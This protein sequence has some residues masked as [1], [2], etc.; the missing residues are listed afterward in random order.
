MHEWSQNIALDW[1]KLPKGEYFF[2]VAPLAR[3]K[4]LK[5]LGLVP[6][7]AHGMEKNWDTPFYP[8]DR[9]KDRLFLFPLEKDCLGYS[10]FY[11]EKNS[12][13]A[14][15][16]R[17]EVISGATLYRDPGYRQNEIPRRKPYSFSAANI[18]IPAGRLE[19]CPAIKWDGRIKG[20]K[21][22]GWVSLDQTKGPTVTVR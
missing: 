3:L 9:V 21:S 14:L 4:M 5:R 22:L 10:N 8:N 13:I 7:A 19:T 15:R 16:F 12:S 17:R 11:E 18:S 6:P 2:H 1:E 20:Y